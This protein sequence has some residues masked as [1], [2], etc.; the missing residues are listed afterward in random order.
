MFKK[1]FAYI[2][3]V[4]VALGGMATSA[5][6]APTVT[7]PTGFTASGLVDAVWDAMEAPLYVILGIVLTLAV[8]KFVARFIRKG[9]K[10]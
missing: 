5:L 3:A 7:L 8:I 9:T 1:S 2:A 10:A 4:T 6:A